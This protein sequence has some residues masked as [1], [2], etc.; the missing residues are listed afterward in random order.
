MASKRIYHILCERILAEDIAVPL[1]VLLVDL[2]YLDD[3]I[4][5]WSNKDRQYALA[6]GLL[7]R[8]FV[9][10]ANT[11]LRLASLWM[12][13]RSVYNFRHLSH[14]LDFADN[15]YTYARQQTINPAF[16]HRNIISER[17]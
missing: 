10:D 6:G 2:W 14:V 12:R 16:A 8:K 4:V 13:L 11:S 1:D 3:I 15:I 9:N 17:E 7:R 5:N